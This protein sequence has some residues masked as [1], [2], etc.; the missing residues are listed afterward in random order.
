MRIILTFSLVFIALGLS[1]SDDDK[2][3]T[4]STTKGSG[5]LIT[6][7]RDLPDF[8]SLVNATVG[9]I[10]LTSGASQSVAIT[11]DDNIID[12]ILTTVTN[13][14]LVIQ[15]APG[16]NISDYTLTIAITMTD[17]E[18]ITLEGVGDITG[19]NAFQVDSIEVT[20]M[21]V[22][23]I[24]LEMEADYLNT[25]HISGVGNHTFS[26][27]ADKHECAHTGVGN[28]QAFNLITDTTE[29]DLSAVGNAEVFVNNYLNVHIGAS[30]SV[31]YK[32]N[33]TIHQSGTGSGQVIDAN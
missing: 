24:N 12:H 7:N 23:S 31:Y 4:P 17:L 32:G 8:H 22:G 1:C 15:I 26:G 9:H 21:G 5:D 2:S 16:S 3:V 25:S 33:P 30:G 20:M 18:S 11:V 19:Q 13:E 6:V 28:I 10:F 29:I 27:S 14:G